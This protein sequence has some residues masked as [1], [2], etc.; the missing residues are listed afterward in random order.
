VVVDIGCVREKFE[1]GSSQTGLSLPHGKP[2]LYKA[3][4]HLLPPGW[5]LDFDHGTPMR[6]VVNEAR[7]KAPPADEEPEG[8]DVTPVTGP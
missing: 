8:A 5:G 7:S 2:G 1:L 3:K 4:L 6:T